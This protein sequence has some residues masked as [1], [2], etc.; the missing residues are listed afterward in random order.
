MKFIFTEKKLKISDDL[1]AFAE[2]KISKIDRYF[3]SESEA[4]VTFAAERG[5]FIAEVTVKNNG[6]FY[7]VTEV[8][9]DMHASI[10]SAVGSIERQIRKHKTRL[11]KRLREGVMEPEY[12]SSVTEIVQEAETEP[13]FDIVRTKM[14]SI[15]P[16][17]PEE[18]VLQLNL[19]DHE[20]FV[21]KNQEKDDAFSI[22]YRRKKGGY[23]IIETN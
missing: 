17:S 16:M 15:K 12:E 10:D 22:V 18:A 6:M 3:K 8:T 2:K 19:L 11:S 21:F 4:F 13:D 7:R 5:R 1:K 23:G 20:F 9:S 14:F